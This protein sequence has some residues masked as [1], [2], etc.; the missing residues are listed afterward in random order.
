MLL[1]ASVS[2]IFWMAGILL[3]VSVILMAFVKSARKDESK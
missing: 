2:K 3:V 1:N